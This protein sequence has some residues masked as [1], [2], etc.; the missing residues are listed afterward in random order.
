MLNKL[1][2]TDIE[3][4]KLLKEIIVDK[5][6]LSSCKDLLAISK[7][8][9]QSNS[10]LIV[11]L[12]LGIESKVSHLKFEIEKLERDSSVFASTQS[13]SEPVTEPNP[14]TSA[15]QITKK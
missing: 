15:K 9:S 14:K 5:G 1:G 4:Y 10:Y 6:L 13:T 8:L 2:S 11:S 12:A 7:S 3:T